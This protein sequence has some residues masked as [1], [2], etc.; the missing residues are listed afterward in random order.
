MKLH[1]E[2]PDELR[3]LT[4]RVRPPALP[5]L[6]D[7]PAATLRAW[8]GRDPAPALT[9]EGWPAWWIRDGDRLSMIYAPSLFVAIA[10][11]EGVRDEDEPA[12][13]DT[14]CAA[15][16]DLAS[17]DVIALADLAGPRF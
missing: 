9:V 10:H 2:I 13:V 5:D 1:L 11:V 6:P 17:E 8:T 3:S 16:I 12:V 15:R 4:W 14:L 7:L